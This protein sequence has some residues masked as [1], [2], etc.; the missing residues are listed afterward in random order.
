VRRRRRWSVVIVMTSMTSSTMVSM[1]VITTSRREECHCPRVE[2]PALVVLENASASLFCP[3]LMHP[4]SIYRKSLKALLNP[5]RVRS[6]CVFKE[7]EKQEQISTRKRKK[8]KLA[9]LK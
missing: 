2:K 7:S 4:F 5:T 1:P 6:L 8:K 3:G 9:A